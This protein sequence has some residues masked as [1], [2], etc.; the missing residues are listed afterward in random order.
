MHAIHTLLS[1]YARSSD[2][3]LHLVPWWLQGGGGGRRRGEG[4]GDGKRRSEIPE[5]VYIMNS[6]GIIFGKKEREKQEK[7][8]REGMKSVK[9]RRIV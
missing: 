4:E 5:G 6:A 7:A 9:C 3:T 1:L 2:C 8:M